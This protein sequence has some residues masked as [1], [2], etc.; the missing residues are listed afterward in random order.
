MRYVSAELP[1]RISSFI[2]SSRVVT[3]NMMLNE[4][5]KGM[6]RSIRV[7]ISSTFLDM[8]E[9]RDYLNRVIF[10]RIKV[11]CQERG[12]SFFA[13]D[14]RWGITEAQAMNKKTIELCL[15]QVEKSI[16]YFIGLLGNRYGWIPDRDDVSSEKLD[17]YDE[18]LQY[19][20]TEIEFSYFCRQTMTRDNCFFAKKSGAIICPSYDDGQS[21]KIDSFLEHIQREI[22]FPPFN[23]D[24]IEML[25]EKVFAVISDWLNKQFPK[26]DLHTQIMHYESLLDSRDQEHAVLDQWQRFEMSKYD[27]EEKPEKPYNPFLYAGDSYFG[28]EYFEQEISRFKLLTVIEPEGSEIICNRYWHYLS[29]REENAFIGIYLDASPELCDAFAMCTFLLN[30]LVSEYPNLF[31]DSIH[32]NELETDFSFNVLRNIISDILYRIPKEHPLILCFTNLHL[33]NPTDINYNL[34]FLGCFYGENVSIYIST[35]DKS[36]TELLLATGEYSVRRYPVEIQKDGRPLLIARFQQ[37][38][39]HNGKD[40]E[41]EVIDSIFHSKGKYSDRDIMMLAE[42]LMNY[43]TFESI[44]DVLYSLLNGVERNETIPYCIF[45]QQA[46]NLT[47]EETETAR[48][49]LSVLRIVPLDEDQLFNV[50]V[51][52][53]KC[54]AIVF[55]NAFDAIRPVLKYTNQGF[56][57]EDSTT[58]K[59]LHLPM[60]DYSVVDSL[61]SVLFNKLHQLK[62]Y[63]QLET[64]YELLYVILSTKNVENSIRYCMDDSVI[65]LSRNNDYHLLRRA[66]MFLIDAGEFDVEKLYPDEFSFNNDSRSY[67]KCDFIMKLE[68]SI[69]RDS[70]MEAFLDIPTLYSTDIEKEFK[71]SCTR[72]EIDAIEEMRVLR[73][74]NELSRCAEQMERFIKSKDL[75]RDFIA[76]VYEN[77]LAYK[78]SQNIKITKEEISEYY[79]LAFYRNNLR[80]IADALEYF[81]EYVEPQSTSLDFKKAHSRFLYFI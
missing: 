68:K 8:Q 4:G 73:E 30:T 71:R 66:W 7:F 77:L 20:A 54:N 44:H 25:G 1:H 13:C 41:K 52:M 22:G 67:S 80:M 81:R 17:W 72:Q 63:P 9:E 61:C 55:A 45:Q 46:R 2:D 18:N 47:V 57:L 64:A 78:R 62:G 3:I 10:P 32:K 76:Y 70:K 50:I 74:K 33:M 53:R 23:Y 28:Y 29:Q 39:Q 38:L 40:I 37:M 11:L 51:S 34:A 12:V 79:F 60:I 49:M 69:F 5:R 75:S 27:A 59:E 16:P 42:Y 21:E 6:I 35:S 65:S 56:S 15:N 14:L 19:S 31:T 58:L 36:Q 43:T 24:R 48:Y 26:T